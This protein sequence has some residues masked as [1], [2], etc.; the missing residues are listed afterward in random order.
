MRVAWD[1]GTCGGGV[2]WDKHHTQ[3][4]TASNAGPALSAA[5]LYTD[6]GEQSYLDWASKVY[7]F[8]N[9]TMTDPRTGA[10]TDH[11]DASSCGQDPGCYQRARWGGRRAARY[12]ALAYYIIVR[13]RSQK[14]LTDLSWKFDTPITPVAICEEMTKS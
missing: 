1:E 4:A 6:T 2:W 5:L 11:L 7:S 12:L 8:W 9:K 13:E 3:K 14:K 10:V